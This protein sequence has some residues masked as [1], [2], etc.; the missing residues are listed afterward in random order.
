[1]RMK[2]CGRSWMS[3]WRKTANNKM[4]TQQQ[5]INNAISY[6]GLREIDGPESNPLLLAII[7]K[8]ITTATDDSKVA[9]C[10]VFLMFLCDELGVDSRGATAAARSWLDVG[11]PIEREK[12]R[13]G[14]IVVFWRESKRSW[15]GHAGI[16][17]GYNLDGYVLTISGNDSNG[18]TFRAFSP[19]RVLGYRRILAT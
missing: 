1:M 11:K 2:L 12:V 14:D 3:G 13:Q 7:Q 6:V 5:F 16:F 10:S 19:K 8:Y 4:I 15:K 9:W 17:W 18:V